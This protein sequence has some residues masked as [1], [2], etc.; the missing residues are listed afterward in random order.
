MVRISHMGYVDDLD[1]L[2]AIAAMEMS[3]RE[4]GY[5]CEPGIGVGAFMKMVGA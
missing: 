5:K 2:S 1:T 3:L 4:L